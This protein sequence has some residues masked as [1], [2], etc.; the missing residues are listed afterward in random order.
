MVIV[1]RARQARIVGAAQS[2]PVSAI[3]AVSTIF[4]GGGDASPRR[5]ARVKLALGENICKYRD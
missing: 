5:R 2:A 4:A 1:W 3:H